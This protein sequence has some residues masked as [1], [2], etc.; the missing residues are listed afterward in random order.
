MLSRLL[1]VIGFTFCGALI[2]YAYASSYTSAN[3]L[4]K[5]SGIKTQLDA[6][7]KAVLLGFQASVNQAAHL[8]KLSKQKNRFYKQLITESYDSL[9]LEKL[10]TDYVANNL[11]DAE[12]EAAIKW[13]DSPL[14]SK[15]TRLEESVVGKESS[16]EMMQ[17]VQ[18]LEADPPP[19][20]FFDHVDKLA[21]DLNATE[22]AVNM[23]MNAQLAITIAMAT[24]EP[25]T[26]AEQLQYIQKEL[27]QMRSIIQAV[28]E[29]E[30]IA[31]LMFTYRSIPVSEL[32]Q[33]VRFSASESG[34]K[35]Q[36]TMGN[37]LSQAVSHG[38]QVLGSKLIKILQDRAKSKTG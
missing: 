5:K 21:N 20:A 28:V 27:K 11:T 23:A 9:E 17:Y 2:T 38:S 14:G 35:Y 6:I 30:V 31:N 36:L 25:N 1:I 33:Y 4:I 10:V 32:E 24:V 13:L 37:A 18:S 8:E 3:T 29:K 26:T 15:I 34:N 22:I 19:Q 7:P 12:I 16:V